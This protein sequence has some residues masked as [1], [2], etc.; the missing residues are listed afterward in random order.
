MDYYGGGFGFGMFGFIVMIAWWAFIIWAVATGIRWV[1]RSAS[2]R[3]P[4][5]HMP[6]ALAIAKQRYAKGELTREEYEEI[7]K[8]LT[9]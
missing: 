4:Q 8:E 3:H 6:S 2:D 1:V 9:K 7:K 5:R